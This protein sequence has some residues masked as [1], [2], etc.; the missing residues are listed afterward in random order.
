M[1]AACEQLALAPAV[2]G[3]FTRRKNDAAR[4]IL[5]LKCIQKKLHST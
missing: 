4:E 2:H 5:P 3:E 1:D